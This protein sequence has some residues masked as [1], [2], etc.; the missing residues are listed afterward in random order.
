MKKI[1]RRIGKAHWLWLQFSKSD[2]KILEK[3]KTQVN[4]NFS[5]PKFETHLT[6]IGPYLK[7]KKKNIKLIINKSKKIKK[8]KINLIKYC[9]QNNKFTSF[10]IKIEKSKKLLKIRQKFLNTGYKIQNVPYNPHISLFY[11]KIKKNKKIKLISKLPKLNKTC[12]VEKICIVDVNESINQW[13]IIEKI[14]L[15]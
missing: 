13:K 4:K 2:M 15:N 9:F 11:G 6:L 3:I 14:K 10:Y 12:T 5:G 7:F 1:P 8:F